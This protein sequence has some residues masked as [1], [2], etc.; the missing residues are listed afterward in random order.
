MN[1]IWYDL[2]VKYAGMVKVRGYKRL[3]YIVNIMLAVLWCCICIGH[4]E[5]T[6]TSWVCLKLC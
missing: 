5:C 2:Y 6:T 1:P 4:K 3:F